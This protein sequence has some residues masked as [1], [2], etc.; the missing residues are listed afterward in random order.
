[1]RLESRTCGPANG[2][3]KSNFGRSPYRH[4]YSA[5]AETN[6][7]FLELDAKT[8]KLIQTKMPISRLKLLRRVTE[9]LDEANELVSILQIKDEV[10]SSHP[11]FII[12]LPLSLQKKCARN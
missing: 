9:R 8:L 12:L 6:I 11:I 2:G 4:T 3:R 1:M 7:T 10:V 5:V